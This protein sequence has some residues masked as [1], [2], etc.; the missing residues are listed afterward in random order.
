MSDARL[1]QS[2]QFIRQKHADE[3]RQFG[4]VSAYLR[5]NTAVVD[6]FVKLI[7]QREGLSPRAALVA[8][9]GYGRREM[10]PYSD[11]DILVLLPA[12]HDDKTDDA[13]GRFV[14]ALW[15]LGMTVGSSVRTQAE[16]V[17]AAKEDI[18]VATAFLE[19]RFLAGDKALFE[20]TYRSYV[21]T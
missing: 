20:Q 17:A 10:F 7:A 11:I 15:N 4:R 8:V 9:G 16:M 12:D 5:R 1:L 14:T 13:T 21:K 18:T 6:Q 19:A 2:F 3:F